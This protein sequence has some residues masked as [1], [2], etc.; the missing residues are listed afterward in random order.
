[1]VVLDMND[2]KYVGGRDNLHYFVNYVEESDPLIICVHECIYTNRYGNEEFIFNPYNYSE[3][4]SDTIVFDYKGLDNDEKEYHIP[5]YLNYIYNQSSVWVKESPYKKGNPKRRLTRY[6]NL[7][8][9]RL[10]AKYM[11]T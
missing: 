2:Y 9:L 3:L 1:M 4:S 10:A 11:D 6:E 8:N 7:A 5:I